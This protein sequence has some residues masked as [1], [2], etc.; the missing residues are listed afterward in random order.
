MDIPGV[1]A[2]DIDIQVNGPMMTV[3]AQ[4]EE[5]ARKKVARST[6]SSGRAAAT[7]AR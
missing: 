5:S 6:A 3:T 7:P 4:R 1:K 2:K